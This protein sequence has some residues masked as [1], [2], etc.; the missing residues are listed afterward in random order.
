MDAG[1]RRSTASAG[2]RGI[3]RVIDRRA[4]ARA[5]VDRCASVRGRAP[6]SSANP[7]RTARPTGD[8]RRCP[9]HRARSAG[10]GRRS[11]RSRASGRSRGRRR[12]ERDVCAAGEA[13]DECR[14]AVPSCR[15]ACGI[16]G[17]RSA[18]RKNARPAVRNTSPTEATFWMNGSGIG[19]T[20]PNGPRWSR[21]VGVE[22]RRQDR[23]DG[24]DDVGR[25]EARRRSG[26][27]PRSACS[28]R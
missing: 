21:N 3:G 4:R 2:S 26:W 14:R 10:R 12:L 5:G 17:R 6:A 16:R 27:A 20:S 23:V 7:R 1:G 13:A 8:A 24:A 28:R 25:L 9:R 11:R 15:A 22:R 19:M 18:N